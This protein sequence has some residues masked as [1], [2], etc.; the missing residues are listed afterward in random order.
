MKKP[1]WLITR[2]PAF[3][4]GY[5]LFTVILS[6]Y[7]FVFTKPEG[8]LLINQFHFALLDRLFVLFTNFGNGIFAILLMIFML[9]RKKFGWS[10]QI[11]VSFLVSGILIQILK[12]MISSPRPRLYFGSGA[13]HYIHGITGTG[14]GSFPSGHATT[15]FAVTSLLA[16][17]FPG[18]NTGNFFI[19][20][21][22][23]T[24]FSRIYLSQHFPIDVLA[25][26]FLGMVVSLF[27]YQL[28]PLR[29]F[30]K[31]F[32]EKDWDRQSI[33]LR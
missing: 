3:F 17:Y 16:L 8:F 27:T 1:D 13:I 26:S 28:I 6:I 10:L 24:G 14:Y 29:I 25:G 18:R 12:N 23:L 4:T 7:C 2:N 30:E 9:V 11:G 5:F 22:C 33:K 20:I 31:K 15:I 21:A 32:Q 19:I